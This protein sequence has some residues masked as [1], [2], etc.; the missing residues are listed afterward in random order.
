MQPVWSRDGGELYY[1]SATHLMAARLSS[2]ALPAV[3][4][5]ARLFRDTY[6]RPQGDNHT[7]YDVFPDGTF[8]FIDV[9]KG[10]DTLAPSFIAVFNWFEE[11]K[12]TRRN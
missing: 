10:A 3:G 1:R 5:P 8:V 4:Q 2:G 12:G 7:G 9:L 6:L 11:L